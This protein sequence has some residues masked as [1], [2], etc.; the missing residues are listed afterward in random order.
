MAGTRSHSKICRV[1]TLALRQVLRSGSQCLSRHIQESSVSHI[2]IYLH[3][4]ASICRI[5]HKAIY[6]PDIPLEERVI[7]EFLD[8]KRSAES[9][10]YCQILM[11]IIE[12]VGPC[13]VSRISVTND[14]NVSRVYRGCCVT[15]GITICLYLTDLEGRGVS[16]VINNLAGKML[17]SS[18]P[19]D[20]NPTIHR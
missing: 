14:G 20:Q 10:K 6:S 15:K 3:S 4:M 12:D 16:Y 9:C 11:S 13:R 19:Y 18:R 1:L 7:F 8:V 5:C 17:L 2:L